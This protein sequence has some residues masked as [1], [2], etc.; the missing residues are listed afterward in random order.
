MLLGPEYS[1]QDVF[2]LHQIALGQHDG[3]PHTYVYMR[4]CSSTVTMQMMLTKRSMI[5]L[6]CMLDNSINMSVS[7]GLSHVCLISVS[8]YRL[9]KGITEH[10][11]YLLPRNTDPSQLVLIPISPLIIACVL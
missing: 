3:W 9:A 10:V 7:C 4:T 2:D 8:L 6:A 5:V 1:E 11:A